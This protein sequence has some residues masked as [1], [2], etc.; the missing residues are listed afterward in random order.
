MVSKTLL[1]L[2]GVLAQAAFVVGTDD[3]SSA[4]TTWVTVTAT[5]SDSSPTGTESGHPSGT[6]HPSTSVVQHGQGYS[7][8]AP[9]SVPGDAAGIVDH[10]FHSW[11][12]PVH[13]WPDYAGNSSNPN[14]FSKSLVKI[15]A[16]KVGVMPH[17][18]VG[19]TSGDRTWFVADQE[20]AIITTIGDNGIP[21]NVSIGPAFYEGFSNFPGALYTYQTNL[22]HNDSDALQN[23]LAMARQGVDAIGD[24]LESLE[25]GN[26]VD[27][28][29]VQGVRPP[30]Y[31]NADYVREWLSYAE[32]I[33]EQVLQGKVDS[34]RI[35]QALTYSSPFLEGDWSVEGAY[36]AGIDQDENIKSISIH[37]YMTGRHPGMTLQHSF[38]NHT[39]I[40]ANLS[41]FPPILN[42]LAQEHPDTPLYLAEDNSDTY[43]LDMN[44]Y[45]GVFGSALWLVDYML[46]AMSI[47]I[48]RVY[49]QQGT[50][51]GFA[52]WQPVAVDGLPPKVR[53]PYYGDLFIADT[54]GQTEDLQ[55]VNVDL[56]SAIMSAY[57][58]YGKGSLAKYAVVNLEEWNS[59]ESGSR[60]KETVQLSVPDNVNSASVTW[61][62][63]SGANAD[64][65][66]TWG[67]Q[68]W[69][70]SS[71]ADNN[72][73]ITGNAHKE[74]V[75]SRQGH[76]S[77]DIDASQGALIELHY[78]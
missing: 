7:V 50:I 56:D 15:I 67:G 18:R 9:T 47:G 20:T 48:P 62:S 61:L 51:F 77:L 19:G 53:A 21:S 13:F 37:Q 43:T 52:S 24:S 45:E 46:Y 59:T 14:V 3:C 58:L 72:V 38:M 41:G 64:T 69:N 17:I 8:T 34:Q 65:G 11:A 76:L 75:Q 42:Y 1:A 40:A 78:S 6:A 31:N 49:I 16:D 22:A 60:P 2:S 57:A 30:S 68:S 32:A 5:S 25:I 4:S 29:P 10:T 36:N 44:E 35:F 27:L 66:I 73:E 54:I 33:T 28:Y 70:Y 12:S 71:T 26:E 63:A 55:V 23:A 74:T 39:E